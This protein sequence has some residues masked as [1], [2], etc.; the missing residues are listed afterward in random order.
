MELLSH[1]VIAEKIINLLGK[2]NFILVNQEALIFTDF[3]T[4][5]TLSCSF[6]PLLK[7][8]D[9]LDLK[10]INDFTITKTSSSSLRRSGTEIKSST[11]SQIH[12]KEIKFV[13]LEARQPKLYD[14]A[15]VVKYYLEDQ[16][17]SEELYSLEKISHDLFKDIFNEVGFI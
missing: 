2:K 9:S 15:L 12:Q 5:A 14:E 10:W 16:S 1:Q 17:H 6:L 3:S 4:K 11:I 8:Q 7:F 13:A